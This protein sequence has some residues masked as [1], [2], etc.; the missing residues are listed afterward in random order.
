MPK[1]RNQTHHCF[2]HQYTELRA[3]CVNRSSVMHNA[4][5]DAKALF[6]THGDKSG[7]HVKELEVWKK[8]GIEP[9]GA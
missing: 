4:F 1:T 5:A 6:V 7:T 3:L 9:H 2:H 8:A